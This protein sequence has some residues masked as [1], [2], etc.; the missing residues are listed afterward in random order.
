LYRSVKIKA[1]IVLLAW[2]IVFL[3]GVIPHIHI[4]EQHGFC[5]SLLHDSDLS[6][7][8]DNS[9]DHIKGGHHDHEK[10]CHFS[11]IMLQQQGFD[12]LLPNSSQK[13]QIIPAAIILSE[14]ITDQDNIL[15]IA[16]TG[17]SSLRAP[18]EA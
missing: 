18:P 7:Q 9:S 2:G 1:V 10:I 8:G 14:L 15:S 12:D 16:E 3:H 13:P 4:S 5:H 6:E 11:T 17:P